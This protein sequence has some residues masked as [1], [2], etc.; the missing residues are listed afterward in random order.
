MVA[1]RPELKPVGRARRVTRS[2]TRA[3]PSSVTD[4]PADDEG[5]LL[6]DPLFRRLLAGEVLASASEGLFVVCLVLLVV[7]VAGPGGTLGLVLAVAAIPRAVLLPFGG[8]LADRVAAARIVVV[9]TFARAALLTAL[10]V[11]VLAGPP[12]IAVIATLAGLLGALD[13][14]YFPAALTLLPQV[15]DAP[16]LPRA[17]ALVQSAES[18]GDLFGPAVAAGAV[19]VVGLGGALGVVSLLYLLAA[20]LLAAFARRLT[21]A[22]PA[23]RVSATP[24]EASATGLAALREGLR[25]GWDDPVVR[26]LLVVLAVLNVAIIG[27]VLVGGAVLA[28][29]RFGGAENLA[30]VFAG[31][32]VGSLIGFAAAGARPPRRRGLV[33]VAGV[34]ALGA[35]TVALGLAQSLEVAAAIAAVMGLA[36]AYLGVTVVAWLQE[37]VADALRGRVMSLVAFSAVALDPLSYLLAGALLPAGPTVLFAASGFIALCCAAAIVAVSDLREAP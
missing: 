18:A 34:A 30:V 35:S 26:L 28:E 11:L 17:N 4:E 8:L 2:A 33:L 5:G 36:E 13:A 14:A 16:R 12:P 27:P 20:V 15:V 24:A 21:R 32:G 19:T 6:R 10:A 29:Q 7:D 9:A 25:Y 37:R 3:Q 23:S 22:R 1:G 31:F